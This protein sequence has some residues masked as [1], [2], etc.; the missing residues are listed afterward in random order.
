MLRKVEPDGHTSDVDVDQEQLGESA[1]GDSLPNVRLP[2]IP[3]P[4]VPLPKAL[5]DGSL[6]EE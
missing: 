5:P 4:D 3:F 1:F 2:D 6:G